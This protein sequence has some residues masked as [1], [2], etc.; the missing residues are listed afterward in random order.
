MSVCAGIQAVGHARWGQRTT[1]E[2]LSLVLF[3]FGYPSSLPPLF[4]FFL[5]PQLFFL[6]SSFSSPPPPPSFQD[7]VCCLPYQTNSDL[8]SYTVRLANSR[9][10]PGSTFPS[11]GMTSKWY[12]LQHFSHTGSGVH[13]RSL[14]S[15]SKYFTDICL[16]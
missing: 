14:F 7:R 5:L 16:F 2:C 15:S 8:L 4:L 11:P 13:L 6:S 12:L 1:L 10:P 9:D 3:T